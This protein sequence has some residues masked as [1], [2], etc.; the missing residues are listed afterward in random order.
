MVDSWGRSVHD[1]P[2]LDL[3]PPASF[4]RGEAESGC[5]N[6]ASILS[7]ILDIRVW[8]R[9]VGRSSWTG[10]VTAPLAMF[11]WLVSDCASGKD[12]AFEGVSAGKEVPLP[13]IPA[14][15]DIVV[16]ADSVLGR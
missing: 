9:G 4:G 3:R 12:S 15:D 7:D 14:V 6:N 5:S 1:D 16:V 10:D 11:P 13:A 8:A 2:D